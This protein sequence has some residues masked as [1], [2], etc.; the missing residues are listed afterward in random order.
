MKNRR[1]ILFLGLAGVCGLLTATA[2][3][4]LLASGSANAAPGAPTVAVV[5]AGEPAPLGQ[6]ADAAKPE[7]AEYPQGLA[8]AGAF[9]SVDQL[10]G[11]V[12]ARSLA[13]GEPILESALLPQGAEAGLA[14]LIAETSRAVSVKVDEFIGVAGF[15]QPGSRVDVIGT[16]TP[17]ASGN[18]QS[19]S[20]KVTQVVIQNVRVL[21]VDDRVEHGKGEAQKEIKVVTLEVS[22][23]QAQALMHADQEGAIK[24]ALR[25]PKDESVSRP[26]QVVLGTAVQ[27][28]RF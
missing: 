17:A 9:A 2:A 15:V 27:D 10:Q 5:V 23:R 16:F 24:L 7:L 12:L 21:A 25:N 22:P 6:A 1:A 14:S 18:E 28:V 19:T 13:K 20:N 4:D 11:R 8:P 26:V 3:R